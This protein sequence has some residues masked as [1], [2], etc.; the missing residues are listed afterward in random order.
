MYKLEELLN[1]VKTKLLKKNKNTILVE[2]LA[3]SI[4]TYS[5]LLPTEIRIISLILRSL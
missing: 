3:N 2:Q 5:D 1:D 4:L